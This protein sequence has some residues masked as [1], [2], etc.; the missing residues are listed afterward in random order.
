MLEQADLNKSGDLMKEMIKG[1]Q[2]FFNDGQ[3]RNTS[4]G[5]K[6]SPGSPKRSPAETGI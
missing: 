2:Q 5:G 1:Q 4:Q 3:N 6:E